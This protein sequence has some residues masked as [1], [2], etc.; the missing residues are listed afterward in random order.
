M[1]YNILLLSRLV[2]DDVIQQSVGVFY[3]NAQ[4]DSINHHCDRTRCGTNDLFS[5]FLILSNKLHNEK[6]NK[7]IIIFADTAEDIGTEQN[8]DAWCLQEVRSLHG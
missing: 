5:S 7:A 1:A 6:A 4:E 8:A 3:N 2:E